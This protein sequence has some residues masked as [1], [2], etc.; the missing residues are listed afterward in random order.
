MG[1]DTPFGHVVETEPQRKS[2]HSNCHKHGNGPVCPTVGGGPS[3]DEPRDKQERGH[4]TRE[5]GQEAAHNQTI[6]RR[7]L[8]VGSTFCSW[9]GLWSSA[10]QRSRGFPIAQSPCRVWAFGRGSWL[11]GFDAGQTGVWSCKPL[12]Y[13][14][15]PTPSLNRK[16]QRVRPAHGRRDWVAG[17]PEPIDDALPSQT[18]AGMTRL[19]AEA[20]QR[21]QM[22]KQDC[23]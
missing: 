23:V 18:L 13:S 15:A 22:N 21:E 10:R 7:R 19:T 11:P 9:S 3:P 12:S 2:K 6:A 16:C 8:Q 4:D 5:S 20:W 17:P 1:D 14:G